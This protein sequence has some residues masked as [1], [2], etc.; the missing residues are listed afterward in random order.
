MV[1]LHFIIALVVVVVHVGV[2]LVV[3]VVGC[4]FTNYLYSNSTPTASI[5]IICIHR[6]IFN[7]NKQHTYI[8]DASLNIAHVS[9]IYC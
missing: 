2:P 7:S 6:S 1:E 8:A 4:R 5:P 9:L 3:I